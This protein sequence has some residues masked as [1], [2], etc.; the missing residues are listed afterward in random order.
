[1]SLDG[2][3]ADEN[4]GFDWIAGGGDSRLDTGEKWDFKRFLERVDTVVMGRHSYDQGLGS[5]FD[6]KQV[7]V[8]TSRA[9]GDHDNVRFICDDIVAAVLAERER[10]GRD[11]YL[12]G[13]S[14]LVKP[15]LQLDLI[16]EYIIGIVPIIL[17]AGQ[18]LFLER[19]PLIQ[20]RLAAYSIEDGICILHYRRRSQP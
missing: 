19:N 14:I 7:W 9:A 2:F 13:G 20:L 6:D 3:I 11:I 17:G 12:F 8:A 18:A 5:D 16:D 15:F 10:D 4:G 1:M